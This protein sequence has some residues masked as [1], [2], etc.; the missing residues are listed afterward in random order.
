MMAVI[1][2]LGPNVVLISPA[3]AEYN[4]FTCKVEMVG[5]GGEAYIFYLTDTG[6]SQAF[7]N[8]KF[9]I[10]NYLKKAGKEKEFLAIALS[11]LFAGKNVYVQVDPADERSLWCMFSLSQ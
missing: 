2:V 10:H 9:F 11:A 7:K 8:K 3:M 1:V 4:W 5:M 6:G